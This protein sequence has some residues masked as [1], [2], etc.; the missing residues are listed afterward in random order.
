M[1]GPR[2]PA[3]ESESPPLSQ[4]VSPDFPC[5]QLGSRDRDQL[6]VMGLPVGT[7]RTE[8]AGELDNGIAGADN[9]AHARP[10]S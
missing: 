8:E 6:E 10:L 4:T 1:S 7:G 9:F 3:P 5:R 2:R